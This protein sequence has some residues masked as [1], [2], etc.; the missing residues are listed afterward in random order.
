MKRD[1]SRSALAHASWGDGADF[2][3]GK[4]NGA[5]EETFPLVQ[6]FRETGLG[7]RELLCAEN[8][9]NKRQPMGDAGA[10]TL[11]ILS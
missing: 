8:V 2:N 10:Q 11:I 5:G 3:K 4:K 9:Q 7:K 1:N 6:S